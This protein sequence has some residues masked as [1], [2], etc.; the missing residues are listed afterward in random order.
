MGTKLEPRRVGAPL[1]KCLV[2]LRLTPWSLGWEVTGH[3]RLS[4]RETLVLEATFTV[5]KCFLCGKWMRKAWI[6]FL[7]LSGLSFPLLSFLDWICQGPV[8]LCFW[9]KLMSW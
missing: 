8:S 3:L 4:G 2:L 9:E 6:Y 1:R 5:A 7:T